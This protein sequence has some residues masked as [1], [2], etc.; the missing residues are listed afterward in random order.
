M[1]LAYWN[2]ISEN[3]QSEILS[4]FDNDIQGMVEEKIA[5]AGIAY[6][7]GTAADIGCGVGRFL[8]SLADVF[9]TVHACDLSPVGIRKAKHRA[10]SCD[11]ISFHEVDLSAESPPFHPVDFVLCV[12]VLIMPAIGQR[13]RAWESV[14]NQVSYKGT[15][16]LVT[17]SAE[18]IQMEELRSIESKI[19]L[20]IGH[21]EAIKD[22]VREKASVK[23]LRLGI[24]QLDGVRTKHYLREELMQLL[25]ARGFQIDSAQKL[26]YPPQ[27][28]ES[29]ESWDWLIVAHR[30]TPQK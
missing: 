23:D 7:E 1:N 19:S 17:P 30:K 8:P 27:S 22:S 26:R 29:Q 10:S 16:A 14:L 18:S 25:S 5:E 21:E 20:G 3:Y 13:M 6:P 28:P 24:H 12:N 9:A 15:L 2:R 4:V 11:N